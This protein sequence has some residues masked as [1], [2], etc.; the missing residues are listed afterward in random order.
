M[1]RPTRSKAGRARVAAGLSE[2]V[3]TASRWRVQHPQQAG[4]ADRN[5]QDHQPA[6]H[7]GQPHRCDPGIKTGAVILCRSVPAGRAHR[8]SRAWLPRARWRAT[9]ADGAP[10]RQAGRSQSDALVQKQDDS[11]VQR[12]H[13]GF[14]RG[15]CAG[16]QQ[17]GG[18]AEC[19]A[20]VDVLVQGHRPIERWP[21]KPSVIVQ[22]G[23]GCASASISRVAPSATTRSLGYPGSAS[24]ARHYCCGR[25]IK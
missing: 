1:R 5:G 20:S 17:L 25:V 13:G 14:Y 8:K 15:A 7:L 11:V 10:G 12:C 6:R 9:G 21:A 19:C 18:N 3:R 22:A 4:E 2:S 23:G 16:Q 24:S